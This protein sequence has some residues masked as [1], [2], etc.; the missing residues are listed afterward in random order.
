MVITESA[1]LAIRRVMPEDAA[2]F[3]GV[4]CS[5]EVMRY[6]DGLRTPAWVRDWISRLTDELYA[7]WGFGPWAVVTRTDDRV[8]GYCGLTREAGRCGDEE[9]ELGF[10]LIR[11]SWGR[12]Y[13]SEA[14]AAACGH[15][16]GDLGLARIVA[17]IDPGNVAS[18]RVAQK[19]GMTYEREITFPGY[20]HPDHLYVLG[21]AVG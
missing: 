19:I 15:G 13:A 5:P 16:L 9:A 8:I 6:S 3:Q 11:A 14:A 20:G 1:R 12:G 10:R 17:I 2:A 4:F 21:A 18:L 7:R